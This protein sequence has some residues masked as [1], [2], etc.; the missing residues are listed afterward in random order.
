VGF[1]LFSNVMTVTG[2]EGGGI[3]GL[4]E[5]GLAWAASTDDVGV[6]GYLVERCQGSGCT[7][8][9]QVASVTTTTFRDTGL[10]AATTYSYRVRATDA[11][12]NLGGYSNTATATTAA[13]PDPP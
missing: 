3:G 10:T 12:G 6:T 7:D 13:G 2:W 5:I 11:G 1:D 4:N 9:A 8:F